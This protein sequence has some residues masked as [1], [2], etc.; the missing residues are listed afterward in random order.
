MTHED[1]EQRWLDVLA[2]RAE[3]HDEDTRKASLLRRVIADEQ[4]QAE[5][6][7]NA[8][9][10]RV[11]NLLRAKGVF[12][13]PAPQAAGAW[14]RLK[15]WLLPAQAGRAV[16]F[17]GRQA[18]LAAVLAG[19]V[20]IPL[21]V[22]HER[23]KSDDNDSSIKGLPGAVVAPAASQPATV[24]DS[25]QALQAALRLVAVLAQHGVQAQIS[26]DSGDMI[27]QAKVPASGLVAT[28]ADLLGIGLALPPDGELTV[29]F[30]QTK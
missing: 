12:D 26:Q 14:L 30:H 3:P 15:Q 28:Q 24:V 8:A 25:A 29:R 2:G 5:P 18:A 9:T 20:A 1:D 16:S 10:T 27:V 21:L 23:N 4:S 22:W 6:L 11:M 7:D 19:V 13:A 17:G